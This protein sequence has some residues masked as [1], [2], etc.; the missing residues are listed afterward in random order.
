MSLLF[1]NVFYRDDNIHKHLRKTTNSKGKYSQ[2]NAVII[3]LFRNYLQLVE[4]TL[5][6]VAYLEVRL[7][8]FI[9][10]PNIA[11]SGVHVSSC[12]MTV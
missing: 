10:N 11:F 8:T 1:M 9:Q 2:S 4:F 7:L 5:L 3:K 12:L 6:A